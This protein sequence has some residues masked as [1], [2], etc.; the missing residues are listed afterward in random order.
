MCA[1]E[2]QIIQIHNFHGRVIYWG[3]FAHTHVPTLFFKL[4]NERWART[5]V[6]KWNSST[7]LGETSLK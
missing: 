5:I 6:Q 3:A 7:A 4:Q 2:S 1:A